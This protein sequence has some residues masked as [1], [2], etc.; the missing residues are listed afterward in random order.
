MSGR[1][2]QAYARA[3]GWLYV[4][5][6]VLAALSM[7]LQSSLIVSGDAAATASRI[8]ASQTQWR[9]SIASALIM[10]TCD[11]PLAVIFYVLLRPVN[12]GLALLSAFFRFA[13]AI[14]GSINLIWYAVPL[15]LLSGAAYLT[16]VDP[17]TLHALTYVALKLYD[18]GFGIALIP[19]GLHCIVLGYLIFRSTYLPR[20]LGV[21]LVLAGAAYIVN[22][23]ALIAAP[24]LAGATF[25][26]LFAAGLP[27]ELGL[28]VWLIVK[29]VNL[30]RWDAVA[31]T[32]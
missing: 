15:L 3:A 12:D 26:A 11:V 6:F 23:F 14:I 10:F 28:C 5:V 8:A 31:G 21:L 30:T 13:E 20:V 19:F 27:A 7:G 2:V 17:R 16:A 29:G 18:N 22:S 4:A 24:A 9:L 1:T 25:I 32:T